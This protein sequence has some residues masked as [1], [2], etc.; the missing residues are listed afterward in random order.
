MSYLI[1]TR[2]RGIGMPAMP[3][4]RNLPP[5]MAS[6][7]ESQLAAAYRLANTPYNVHGPVPPTGL[8]MAPKII[9]APAAPAP[10]Y[11]PV[12]GVASTLST[13]TP[14][15]QTT[16]ASAA[17]AAPASASV[18]SGPPSTWPTDQPY[19]DA[20]G[21]VWTWATPNG[22]Q[23]STPTS[24]GGSLTNLFSN[25]LVWLQSSTIIS[26]LPNWGTLGIG[27]VGAGFLFSMIHGSSHRRR[28]R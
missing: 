11:T 20:A 2:R 16:T 12:S 25:A 27:L 23:I 26:A 6:Q 18:S 22:W 7:V 5:G 14:A 8:P 10:V 19:T 13:R 9:S 1:S 4:L 3:D 24:A 17:T 28:R 21:N 15:P